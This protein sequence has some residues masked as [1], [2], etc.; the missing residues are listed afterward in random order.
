M[1]L[2]TAASAHPGDALSGR[3]MLHGVVSFTGTFLAFNGEIPALHFIFDTVGESD[4]ALC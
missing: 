4:S 3:Q 2:R 1:V